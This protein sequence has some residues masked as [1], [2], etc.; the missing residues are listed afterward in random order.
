MSAPGELDIDHVATLA[1]LALTDAE[2]RKFAA[3][4]GDVLKHIAELKEV[5][6]SG[7][8]PT[9]HA[10]PVFNV[11]AEDVAAPG[12]PVDAALRNAPAQRENMVAVPKVVE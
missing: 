12:L 9:A 3:Q 8:E 6:V 5:D 11:W 7:V 1:R 10:Y 2:K 4:L